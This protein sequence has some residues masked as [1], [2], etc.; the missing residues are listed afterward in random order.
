MLREERIVHFSLKLRVRGHFK[1]GRRAGRAHVPQTF[2]R[3]I[4]L[5]TRFH[6]DSKLKADMLRR[7]I[8]S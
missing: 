1:D 6:P 8:G 2:S 7:S 3:L 4:G 5:N